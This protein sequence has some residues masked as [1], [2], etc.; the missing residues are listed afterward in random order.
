MIAYLSGIYLEQ[1]GNRIVLDV[2]GVGYELLVSSRTLSLLPPIGETASLHVHTA[3]RDDAIVLY[4]FGDREERRLFHLLTLVSGIG[5]KLAL[6]VLSTAPVGRLVQ[7]IAGRDTA[8]LQ[9]VP[10]IGKKTAQRLCMELA[11]KVQELAVPPW[12]GAG[13]GDGGSTPAAG[14]PAGPLAD[15]RSALE[16]L[17]YTGAQAQAALDQ[18]TAGLEPVRAAELDTTELIRMALQALA[19]GR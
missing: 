8:M 12:E 19:G 4:G 11:D 2:G 17:G 16:N 7:A 10:G 14:V 1:E 6:G 3:V 18:V 13:P 15:A 9:Q 5:P